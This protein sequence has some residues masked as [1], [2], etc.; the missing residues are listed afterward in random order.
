MINPSY[1]LAKDYQSEAEPEPIKEWGECLLEGL[2]SSTQLTDLNISLPRPIVDDWLCEGDL[3]FIFAQRGIGKSWLALDL[4]HGIAEK[5]DVGP[6][7]VQQQLPCLYLDGEMPPGII[8][9]RDCVLGKP[10]ACLTYINHEILFQRTGRIMNLADRQFQKAVLE[11][12]ISKGF[13][14]LFLDNLSCLTSGVDENNPLDWEI[15]LPWLLQFRRE[16][17]AVIVVHHAGRNNQM[18]GHSKREDSAFWIIRLDPP[19]NI[20]EGRVGAH[21][22]SNFTKWRSSKKPMTYQWSYTPVGNN[23]EDICV[24][25]K[26]A[27]PINIFRQLVESGLESATEIA[28][29]MDVSRGY[30]S[31]LATRAKTEGWLEINNRRYHLTNT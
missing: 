18:L 20:S 27:S 6:W 12:C 13:K 9:T 17:I 26:A 25:F 15:L 10:S 28:E 23:N 21:F 7:K 4:A 11:L 22:I 1:A 14:V 29:E 2:C 8:K 16:H 24:E 3:G 30:V 19:L 31:Q 5:H